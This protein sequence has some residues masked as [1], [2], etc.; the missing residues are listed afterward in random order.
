MSWN[1]DIAWRTSGA[2][3]QHGQLGEVASL[4]RERAGA[5]TM[6]TIVIPGKAE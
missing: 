6:P 5:I 3:L 4:E 2:G 1:V